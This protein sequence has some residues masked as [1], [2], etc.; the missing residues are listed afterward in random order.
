M[1]LEKAR[2]ELDRSRSER[3]ADK[4]TEL[5]ERAL[6]DKKVQ[7]IP[8]DETKEQLQRELDLLRTPGDLN[9]LT[10]KVEER[11]PE[12]SHEA[13]EL[14]LILGDGRGRLV[15]ASDPY[16]D[17]I[18]RS[19]DFILKKSEMPREFSRYSTVLKELMKLG[20]VVSDSSAYELSEAGWLFL[21]SM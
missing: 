18:M 8:D 19:G 17:L 16:G 14:L 6:R 3:F 20:L 2:A 13:I 1:A 10:E 7:E 5:I 21:E 11:I 15:I 12:P 9:F 4:E